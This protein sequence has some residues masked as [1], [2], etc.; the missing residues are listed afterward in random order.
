MVQVEKTPEAIALYLGCLQIGGVYVPVNTAY[1]LDEVAYF[2][3][4][5]DPK[6]LVSS[7]DV[8]LGPSNMILDS[9]GSGSL[10]VL[11]K[12]QSTNCVVASLKGEELAAILYTSGTT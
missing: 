10:A 2:V 9:D 6:V 3:S 12:S 5:A 11:A 1:T 7:T 8:N 4:D